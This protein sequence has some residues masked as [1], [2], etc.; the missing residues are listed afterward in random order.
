[1]TEVVQKHLR[2]PNLQRSMFSMARTTPSDLVRSKLSTKEIQQRALAHVPDELLDNIPD[3]DNDYSLFQGFQ[4]TFPELTDEGKKHRRRVSRG[5][6]LLDE[7]PATPEGP[8]GLQKL[9]KERAAMAHELE[10]LGIRKS[11][12]SCEIREI[13][14]K[15]ANLYGMRKIILDRLAV[16]EQEETILEH[17]RRFFPL[18]GPHFLFEL[19]QFFLPLFFSLSHFFFLAPLLDSLYIAARAMPANI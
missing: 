9:R 6:R 18:L 5:R 17:D 15:I 14:T 7:G 16:L 2:R 10:M 12:A 3:D 11:M 13:D 19:L 4:A 1:M 8:H